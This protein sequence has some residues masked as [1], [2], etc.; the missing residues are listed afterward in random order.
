MRKLWCLEVEKNWEKIIDGISHFFFLKENGGNWR[1]LKTIEGG[2]KLSKNIKRQFY[3][4]K[5]KDR[6]PFISLKKWR[7]SVSGNCVS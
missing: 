4:S 5:G 1:D 2:A 3:P 6:L 7:G